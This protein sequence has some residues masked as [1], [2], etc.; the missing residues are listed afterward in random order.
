M[1][2]IARVASVTSQV[3]DELEAVGIGEMQVD[4]RDVVARLL[5]RHLG[6]SHARHGSDS[7]TC[8]F[9]HVRNGARDVRIVLAEE[10]CRSG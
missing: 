3:A 8:G 9:E 4:E 1:T 5:Q 2:G 6:L 10:H 7:H